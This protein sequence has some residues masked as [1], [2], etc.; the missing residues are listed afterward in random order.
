MEIANPSSREIV[1]AGLFGGC[2][3]FLCSVLS[4]SIL[5]W[6]GLAERPIGNESE[7][8]RVLSS[9][10]RDGG[11]YRFPSVPRRD[12]R[13]DTQKEEW[14]LYTARRRA[15]P[16]GLIMYVQHGKDFVGPVFRGLALDLMAA[17]LAAFLASTASHR[18]P[19]YYHRV[20][21]VLALGVFAAL[22]SWLTFWNW[23]SLPSSYFLIRAGDAVAGWLL[24]GLV[25][26]WALPSSP[27]RHVRI[28]DG[29]KELFGFIASTAA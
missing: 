18:M 4:W 27:R 24:A 3:L 19:R 25:M 9:N 15:G 17:T 5:P 28:G 7:V 20:L 6:R 14:A 2:A 16:Y 1:T 13:D 22:V 26:A 21:F 23:D 10:L 8:L 12:L 11:T 29:A